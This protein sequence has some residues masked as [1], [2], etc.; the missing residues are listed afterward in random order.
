M[1][2]SQRHIHQWKHNRDFL[3]TIPPQY[4]DWMV[5]A[6][7]YV[8]LHAIDAMLAHDK[9]TVTNHDGRNRVLIQTNRYQFIS[10][11]YLALY[12]LCRTI[13]YLADPKKWVP[14]EKIEADVLKRYPYPIEQ[15]VQKL[16]KQDL[17]FQ[18]IR[19]QA[20]KNP[21]PA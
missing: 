3:L 12:D 1:A 2:N 13:R 19:L 6:S 10:S 15:S 9:V 16:I 14:L 17:S 18:P 8:A 11:K 4:P 20:A 5:T 21:P 7:F